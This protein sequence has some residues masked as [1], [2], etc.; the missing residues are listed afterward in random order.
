MGYHWSILGKDTGN[1]CLDLRK[2]D[3]MGIYVTNYLLG[4]C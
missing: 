2:W 4:G 3:I 1:I